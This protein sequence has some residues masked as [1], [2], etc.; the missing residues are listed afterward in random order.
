VQQE[1]TFTVTARDYRRAPLGFGGDDFVSELFGGGEKGTK[2]KLE[3][4][5]DG[6]YV[7]TF[8]LPARQGSENA[9]TLNVKLRG[10]HI[11]GSPFHVQYLQDEPRKK[12]ESFDG[13]F[14]HPRGVAVSST[15][16]EVFVC[17]YSNHC[18]HVFRCDGKSMRKWG[19]EGG[20][21]GQFR[22][23]VGIAISR[24]TGEVF[25]CDYDNHRVQ[26]FRH[27]GVFVRKFSEIGERRLKNPV[28]VAISDSTS[29]I[30]ICDS[31][32]VNVFR[33]DGTFV[34]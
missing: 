18:V 26:V 10:S 20:N 27:D 8:M 14:S 30:F 17:E 3:D 13:E 9:F 16:N 34:H 29:E 4:R 15:T 6:S 22:R 23:P 12:W 24:E 33:T 31:T 5:E 21:D 2:V 11:V 25:V 7:G 19:S 1:A 28:G 32:S